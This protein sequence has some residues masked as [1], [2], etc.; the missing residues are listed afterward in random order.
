MSL[1]ISLDQFQSISDGKY[2]AG[3]VDVVVDKNG[4]A[5]LK[6]VN[7]HVH[8]TSLNTATIDPAQTLEIKEAFVKALA[9]HVNEKAV[10]RIREDLGLPTAEGGTVRLG[11]A[12]E[13]LTRQQVRVILDT[14][15]PPEARKA[16]AAEATSR[17]SIREKV[18]QENLAAQPIRV[19]DQELKLDKIGTDEIHA[20][21]FGLPDKV[22]GT[23]VPIR[24]HLAVEEVATGMR[25][26]ADS[27]LDVLRRPDGKRAD[28]TTLVRQLNTLAAYA[29]RAAALD[30][31][32]PTHA[33]VGARINATLA[34]ALDR[35]DNGSL[36]T[37]YQGT[38]SRELDGLKAEI[39]RRMLSLSTLPSQV[40]T[41]ERLLEGISRL[42]ARVVSEVSYRVGIE[43]TPQDQKAAVQ[44]PV[45]RWCGDAAVPTAHDRAGE[46]TASNLEILTRRADNALLHSDAIADDLDGRLKSHGLT[47]TDT[48]KIGDMIRGA[49]LT[50]NI[51]LGSIVGWHNG[52]APA[53][54]DP[55]FALRNTFASKEAQNLPTDGSGYLVRRDEVEKYYFPEYSGRQIKG[56]ERPLYAAFNTGRAYSGGIGSSG[57]YGSTVVVLKP[58]VK[59]QA[60]YT[61]DDSFFAIKISTTP[62]S[63]QA[64]VAALARALE[65]KV[66]QETIDA[67]STPGTALFAAID[68][69]YAAQGGEQIY[70]ERAERTV[71]TALANLLADKFNEG[72]EPFDRDHFHAIMIRETAVE[73][74]PSSMTATFDNIEDLLAKGEDF[75]AVGFGVATLRRN[76]PDGKTAPFRLIGCDY[77][78]AQLHGPIVLERDVEEIRIS[79]PEIKAQAV[80]E[81]NALDE[82]P[83]EG[84]AKDKWI[85]DRILLHKKEIADMAAK[86]KVKI[87]FY[88]GTDPNGARAM[89]NYLVDVRETRRH[90][91][92]AN[93]RIA[94]EIVANEM[95][96]LCRR[97]FANLQEGCKAQLAHMFGENLAQLPDWMT[98]KIGTV[99]RQKVLA[100]IRNVHGGESTVDAASIRA[101]LAEKA[102][103]V[104]DDMGKVLASLNRNGVDNSAL[105][106]DIFRQFVQSGWPVDKADAF[107]AARAAIDRVTYSPKTIVAAAMTTG[108]P[109]SIRAELSALGVPEGLPLAGRGLEN[110][111]RSVVNFLSSKLSAGGKTNVDKLIAEAR[112]QIVVPALAKRIALLLPLGNWEF[113]TDADRK[114][115]TEWAVNSGKLKALEEV[116]GVYAASG[117]L[118]DDLADALE[119]DGAP[120][121]GRLMTIHRAFVDV[122]SHYGDL[123]SRAGLEI[124]T[125][126]L[127]AL[128]FRPV[129]VAM[130]RLAL[131]VGQ[132]G[133]DKLGA[134]LSSPEIRSLFAATTSALANAS[135]LA[136][137]ADTTS[138]HVLQ[139]FLLSMGDRLD[140]KYGQHCRFDV[141]QIAPFA[142]VSPAMRQVLS[143]VAPELIGT[144]SAKA[145]YATPYRVM[146]AAANPAGLPTSLAGRKRF[147]RAALP[148]YHEHEK[149]FENGRNTHGRTHATRAFVLANVLGN[150]L[151]ERG[152]PVDMNALSLGIAGHDMGRQGPG[153]DKWER[154]SGD[155]TTELGERLTGDAGGIEW[156]GAVKA[157]IA[158][159]AP[160]LE[161][162]RTIEGYL[163][164]AAD[165]L[166]YSRVKPLDPDHFHFM[167]AAFSCGTVVVNPDPSLRA[168][169]MKEAAELTRLTDPY[170]L[171][172]GKL[173][174]LKV[175]GVSD[176]KAWVEYTKLKDEVIA[177]EINQTDRLSDDQVI[178]FVEQTIR[179]NPE[180]FPLLEKY[181]R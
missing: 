117:K 26:A 112:D 116:K 38:I 173:D 132:E 5:T 113:K 3:Q 171:Q 128:V 48:R 17:V 50:L 16:R 120:D 136:G 7:A 164:K 168:E 89:E 177:A 64:F 127:N 44:P 163:L 80:S 84:P 11:H 122:V 149:T 151:A 47:K 24:D 56:S 51:H 45:K 152:V 138:V 10:A 59:Q 106:E 67:L 125:D 21:G 176:D 13:P 130:S 119:G 63:R 65:G 73:G 74:D 88:D 4:T 155:L 92:D 2:N 146:P 115:F 78:E 52:L 170:T 20:D 25:M 55:H 109:A 105:R 143:G 147:L 61:L 165:S 114:A 154:E 75:K 23:T 95:P 91:M 37:V 145:P 161:T 12:Y 160:E 27:L 134:A 30:S 162:Q 6:K 129:N 166:D 118:A 104:L 18:N 1:N 85:S 98:D 142:T 111:T 58:H 124:G 69:F 141:N 87:S 62:Q 68:S 83:P 40:E 167:E 76:D 133:M 54:G 53:L 90:M 15:M 100:D 49:E 8:F 108:F 28:L 86:S 79:E 178:D 148:V 94:E 32:N 169:L 42:E 35:L 123:A 172:S 36:A 33:D 144:M 99:A 131:R 139:T 29:E 34:S 66:A 41:C 39:S 57:A 159:H 43:K 9:P 179:A 140:E 102:R 70:A 60:T 174:E 81:Y 175:K 72:V 150:I 110:L 46:M 126:D 101:F 181:Y 14:Y 96:A 19:G 93:L 77:I 107:V 180:K 71:C 137:S 82:K 157:N 135:K 97:G 103:N 153:E 158:G 31:A 121:M 156:C 22:E